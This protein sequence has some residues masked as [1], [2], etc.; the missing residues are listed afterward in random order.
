MQLTGPQSIKEGLVV[1]PNGLQARPASVDLHVGSIVI[2][3]KEYNE[4]VDIKAQQ[5]FIIVSKE[6]VQIKAGFV[7]YAMPKTS[8]CNEGIL[9]LNTGIL[10]PGYGGLISTTA[11]NFEEDA[12]AIS[13]GEPFL[14]LV[15]HRLEGEGAA[16]DVQGDISKPDTT[17]LKEAK[18]HSRRF[19]DTFLDIPGQIEAIADRVLK[20]QNTT[21]I[22]MLTIFTVIYALWNLG[23]FALLGRQASDVSK[24]RPEVEQFQ[25][26][27]D[28]ARADV[29]SLRATICAALPALAPDSARTAAKGPSQ[30][31]AMRP[32]ECP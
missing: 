11:I 27:L 15:F 16:T 7:G 13:P 6:R 2:N 26:Q 30:V 23:A 19:P 28:S 9:C 14:R 18:A 32:R 24:S 3:G 8:L 25:Q 10:D 5:M 4:P 29:Q 31:R 22:T 21:M 1:Q 20:K 12:S 17:Y